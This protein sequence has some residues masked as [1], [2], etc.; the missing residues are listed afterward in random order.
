MPG[1]VS[2]VY[3]GAREIQSTGRSIPVSKAKRIAEMH[4]YDQ[5][6]I[7][8]WDK[9]TGRQHVTTYGRTTLDCEQAAVAGNNVK[10]AAGWPES[11]CH[12]KPG[13]GRK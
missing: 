8:A 7:W 12:A 11:E 3:P 10:R 2:D 1:S 4:G 13:R 6:V 5:V 9:A